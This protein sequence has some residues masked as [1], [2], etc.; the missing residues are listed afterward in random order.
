[1]QSI[2]LYFFFNDNPPTVIT[3]LSLHDALPISLWRC[4]LP[5]DGLRVL[6]ALGRCR[7]RRGEILRAR[8]ERSLADLQLRIALRSEEQT[9]EL[10]SRQYLVCR[11][12]LGK[13][14]SITLTSHSN[15]YPL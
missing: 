6:H 8:I 3:T 12:L 15:T 13:K 4:V 2:L 5:R 7:M 9:Y 14:K 10:Q 11:L 1:M